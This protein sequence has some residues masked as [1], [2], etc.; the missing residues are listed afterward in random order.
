[1]LSLMTCQSLVV[2]PLALPP[3]RRHAVHRDYFLQWNEQIPPAPLVVAQDHSG[4]RFARMSKNQTGCNILKWQYVNL[5][6]TPAHVVISVLLQYVSSNTKV[7][8]NMTV[9][10]YHTP[11]NLRL[12]AYPSFNEMD[13]GWGGKRIGVNTEGQGYNEMPLVIASEARKE[14]DRKFNRATTKLVF[15]DN[16]HNQAAAVLLNTFNGSIGACV[17][18]FYNKSIR[19]QC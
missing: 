8:L 13:N 16:P 15:L 2:S 14:A 17:Y 18:I 10:L 5:V 9:K 7:S 4:K 6:T 3:A 11:S 12:T 1:M 19:S